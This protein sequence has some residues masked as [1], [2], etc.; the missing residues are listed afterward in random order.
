M[1]KIEENKDLISNIQNEAFSFSDSSGLDR[2]IQAAGKAK[3]VLLGE[4]SHGTSE[5]YTVRAEISK[6]LIEQKGFNCIAV[7]GDWPSCFTINRYVKGYVPLDPLETLKN[8]NRWPTWMW[9]NEEIKDLITWLYNHNQLIDEHS[10]KAGFY[11]IDIYSLWESM[12][13]IIN[14]LETKEA[15]ELEAAKKAFACFEPFHR[16]PENYA[17]SAALY[18]EGCEKE[19]AD[20]LLKIKNKWEHTRNCEE[21]S[22]NLMLNSLVAVNAENYYR[23]MVKGGPDDWNIRD[24]H[25]VSAIEA[26]SKYYGENA[27]VIVWEHNTHIGDARATDMKEE[28]LVNVGQIL[29][30]KYGEDQIFALGFGTHSGTVIASEQWGD[31]MQV[32]EV[33]PAQAGS[34]EDALQ[35]AGPGDK[36][37]L[38]TDDNRELFN[39]SIGQRAIGVVYNPEYEQYGNYVPTK[40]SLRYDGFIYIEKTRALKPIN[41]PV[42]LS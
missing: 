21:E 33:P 40:V 1:I 14:L 9:A 29:R 13:G 30:E 8:F 11:G 3:F 27:K 4:A 22:L 19:V 20:L 42:T 34:W 36:I 32:M 17:V 31:E 7:E 12:D 18:G 5:F 28:G 39:E 6:R 24:H 15:A 25:M 41:I 10:R 37:L 16:T 23:A 2:I 26:V 35:K 38:F